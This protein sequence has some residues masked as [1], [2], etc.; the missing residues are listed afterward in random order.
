MEEEEAV[1]EIIMEADAVIMEEIEAVIMEE[2]C[3]RI[4]PQL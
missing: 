1:A 4:R 2:L 3:P